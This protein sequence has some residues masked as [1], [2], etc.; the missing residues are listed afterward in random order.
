MVK[1]FVEKAKG[2]IDIAEKAA[3]KIEAAAKA[4][5]DALT[6]ITKYTKENLINIHHI[7]FNTT[8]EKAEGACFGVN[9]DVT[10]FG[11][12]RFQHDADVCFDI[13]FIKN[14][15]KAIADKV[16]PGITKIKEKMIQVREYFKD[17][18]Y[19]KEE[20]KVSLY[21]FYLIFDIFATKFVPPKLPTSVLIKKETILSTSL[22]DL[23]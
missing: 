22:T 2:L 3:E 23:T 10:L 5:K 14:M 15:G 13:S 12:K 6:A 7:C 18:Q 17:A 11:N 19:K 21:F 9:V 8:L 4:G 20:L 16:F 1:T